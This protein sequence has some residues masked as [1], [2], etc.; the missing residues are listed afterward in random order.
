MSIGIGENINFPRNTCVLAKALRIVF[1]SPI[2]MPFSKIE[3][4]ATH[5]KVS[6]MYCLNPL[7]VFMP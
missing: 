1:F 3:I 6:S 2:L 4:I 7:K 5:F